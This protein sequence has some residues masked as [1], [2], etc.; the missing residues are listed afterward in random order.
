MYKGKRVG[1][2]LGGPSSEREVSLRS[3]QAVAA[4]LR[5]RGYDVVELDLDAETPAKLRAAGVE[6]VYNALHGKWGEDGCVQGLLELLR[7]P[8][9]GSGVT[10]SA[11]GMDKVISKKLFESIGLPVPPYSLVDR[12]EYESTPPQTPPYGFPVVVKPATEGS[13]VGVSIASDPEEF[14]A[15]LAAAFQWDDRIIL[16]KYI[17]GRELSVAVLGAEALGLAEIRP[18]KLPDE[19]ISFYDYHHKYTKGMTEY[20]THPDNLDDTVV[21]RV[22]TIAV[23]ANEAIG[24]EGIVRVDFLLDAQN[25]PW[26][27]EVNTLPGMTELSLVPMIARDWRGL[28]MGELVEMVLATA[29]LKVGS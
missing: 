14:A 13:S 23:A 9:T 11:A 20:I 8:Y 18:K 10:A 6:V 21:T 12:V 17:A 16:E 19:K 3:G 27:L 26:L 2:L 28:S 5:G 1:V 24:G 15:A 22:Q 25:R 7:L 4:A 29:R